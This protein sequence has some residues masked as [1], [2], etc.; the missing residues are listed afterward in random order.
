MSTTAAP[1]DMIFD[2]SSY[3]LP[4]PKLDGH[5]ADRLMLAFGGSIELDRT[6]EDHLA[7]IESLHLGQ[8]V[9]L[10][11]EVAVAGKGFSHSAKADDQEQVGYRVN[12]RV[13][14]ISG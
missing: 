4:I 1:E 9:T 3:D 6:L 13:M 10:R 7:L 5:K 14:S 2:A 11:V 8:S 12:L